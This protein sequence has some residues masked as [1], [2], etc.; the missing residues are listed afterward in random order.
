MENNKL[1]HL[2]I[3]GKGHD[4]EK[5][6]KRLRCASRAINAELE[7]SWQHEQPQYLF[8]NT[9][10]SVVVTCDNK[11]LIDGLVSTEEI[12]KIFMKLK[13]HT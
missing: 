8:S 1:L 6:Q 13:G 5:I 4:V 7:L 2:K 10:K 3:I 11:I 12:E 9:N